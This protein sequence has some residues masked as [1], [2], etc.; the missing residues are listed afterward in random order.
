MRTQ[1]H[2]DGRRTVGVTGGTG[3]VGGAGARG[4]A[5]GGG[6][7]GTGGTA[8]AVARDLAGQGCRVLIVGRDAGRG[9]EV[10]SSLDGDGHAMI[11]ADLALLRETSRAADEILAATRRLDAVVLCAGVLAMRPEWT[12]EGLER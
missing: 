7:A 3:G 4:A 9:T 8:R 12:D 1:E 5:R 11:R 6:R 2:Q 10:L